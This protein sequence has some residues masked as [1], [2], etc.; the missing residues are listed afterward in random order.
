MTKI[1]LTRHGHVEGIEPERF[2]GRADVP[3]TELGR[4]QAKAT[5]RRISSAWRPR[6]VYTSPLGRCVETGR[7]IA[8]ACGVTLETLPQLVDIH[9]GQWQWHSSEDVQRKWPHQFAAWHETPQLV[10]F[11]DGDSLQ[12]LLARSAD[13]LRLVLERHAEDTVVL[14]AHDSVN[15]ALV[16][17]LLDL[18]LTGYWRI[19]QHPCGINEID[20]VQGRIQVLRIN[21]TQHLAGVH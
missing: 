20:L 11:P 18:P 3:L 7:E 14:V 9:Y 5:A 15:R 12:D 19:A 8:G 1:V 6:I 10:R 21:E 16:L 2:R 17:Q 13:A 4:A